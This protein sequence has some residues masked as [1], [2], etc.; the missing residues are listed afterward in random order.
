MA[1]GQADKQTD[2]QTGRVRGGQAGRQAD[3]HTGRERGGQ[4][5]KSKAVDFEKTNADCLAMLC[6]EIGLIDIL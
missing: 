6:T 2:K 3:K 1:G 4:G 5:R